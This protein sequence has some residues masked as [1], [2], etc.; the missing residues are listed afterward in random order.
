[1]LKLLKVKGDSLLPDYRDGDFVIMSKIP[2][3]FRKIKPGDIVVFIHPEFAT[4]IKQVE[5]V[6]QNGDEFFLV[7]TH[8]GSID[9]RQFGWVKGKSLMG[10]VIRHI[11]KPD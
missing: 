7:G 10:K 1:M 9:S 11:R 6:S 3:F 4:M 2:V 8:F 5:R